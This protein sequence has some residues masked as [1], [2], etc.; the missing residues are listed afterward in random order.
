[1]L[2][3]SELYYYYIIAMFLLIWSSPVVILAPPVYRTHP[4]GS[5]PLPHITSWL[6]LLGHWLMGEEQREG[7]GEAPAPTE[8]RPASWADRADWRA[9][10]GMGA[11]AGEYCLWGLSLRDRWVLYTGCLFI[12]TTR[13]ICRCYWFLMFKPILWSAA[14]LY[15]YRP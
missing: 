14:T 13:S 3:H 1:M 12:I 7:K 2:L 15:D 8:G 11:T 6:P 5:Q 4:T 10:L 9:S